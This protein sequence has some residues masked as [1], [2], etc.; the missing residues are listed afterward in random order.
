MTLLL[1]LPSATPAPPQ[2]TSRLGSSRPTPQRW[3]WSSWTARCA[4]PLGAAAPRCC[5]PRSGRPS[6]SPRCCAPWSPR[7][8]LMSGCGCCPSSSRLSSASSQDAAA[9]AIALRVPRRLCGRPTKRSDDSELQVSLSL[10]PDSQQA[11]P[12]WGRPPMEPASTAA[13]PQG[14]LLVTVPLS[15]LSLLLL[16]LAPGP[17][18]GLPVWCVGCRLGG[19]RLNHPAGHFGRVPG[20]LHQ[21]P[22]S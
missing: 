9:G 21:Q 20:P 5:W 22:H 13:A 19:R 8:R 15:I 11:K 3:R 10:R 1:L 16:A 18:P 17:W 2:P 14:P 7:A 6:S 12:S 4:A